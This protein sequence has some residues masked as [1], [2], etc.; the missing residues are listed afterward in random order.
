MKGAIRNTVLIV[1]GLVALIPLL[2]MAETSLKPNAEITQAGSLYPHNPTF[3]NYRSLFSGR[4]FGSYLTN[5]IGI[6]SISVL[7]SLVLGSLAAYSIARYRL[8]WNL[9]QH[10]GVGL[11]TLRILPPIV[12]IVPAFLIVERLQLLNTWLGLI[13]I[14][15]AFNV[16]FV[17][18]MMES[19]F[20]EIPVD[21]EEAAM[22]DGDSRLTAFR[23]IV[24]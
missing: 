3:Q 22:V 4:D 10:I 21:L 13:V 20:R 14:Y 2:W 7:V 6:T 19:F 18:W 5:S 9:E 12:I 8:R 23:R 16:S 1:A 17:V 15:S 11:L 24:L